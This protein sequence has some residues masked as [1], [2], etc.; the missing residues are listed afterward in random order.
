MNTKKKKFV[1]KPHFLGD[2]GLTWTSGI[3]F[4]VIRTP[5]AKFWAQGPFG[6]KFKNLHFSHKTPQY[7]I[8]WTPAIIF[9]AI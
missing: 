3:F 7:G 9:E 5:G 6:P 4:E 2:Y 8:A 1:S